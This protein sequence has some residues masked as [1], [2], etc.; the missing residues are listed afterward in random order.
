LGEFLDFV[1][2][3]FKYKLYVPDQYNAKTKAPLMVML[4]GCT[5]DPDDF[6][7]GTNM[8]LLADQEN[9][10]VL[11]P[12]MNHL[13]NPSDPT[14]YNPLGCWNWFLDKNQHRGM[15]HPKLVY[16]MINEVKNQYNID[17]NRIYAAGLSAGG[18]LACIMGV[19]YPDVFSGIAICS[20]MAYDAANV[21]FLTDPL[22]DDAKK[23][24]EKGV[25]NPYTC[26]K[27]AFLEM[28]EYKKKMPIIVFQGLLDTTV[29]PINAQHV[30]IQWAQ[31]N[32]MIEGGRGRT[33][34][35]PVKVKAEVMNDKSYTKHVYADR[36]GEPLMELWMIDQMGHT[37]SGGN[38]N[39]SYTDPSGPNATE[40]IWKFF[41]KHQQKEAK[42]PVAAMAGSQM[43]ASRSEKRADNQDE[44]LTAFPIESFKIEAMRETSVE[45][46]NEEILEESTVMDLEGPH[47]GEQS[48][49]SDQS[50]IEAESPFNPSEIPATEA[51][52]SQ[53]ADST[54]TE[55]SGEKTKKPKKKLFSSFFSRFKKKK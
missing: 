28:G 10:L 42:I 54:T 26:G 16:E 53:G 22:A 14:G 12:N 38:P 49:A 40:I 50:K 29:H 25:P 13:F 23:S 4:H 18:S 1:Y 31:A 15:G 33:D 44:M 36:Q 3:D 32:Y 19:T 11:Y 21:F 55:A 24:M 48:P 9:F 8:N 6:A 2:G 52:I 39:G 17:E 37:W 45:T 5:Q 46:A 41:V 20:G 34:V 43:E 47:D 27:N 30:I 35:T 51:P 7:T